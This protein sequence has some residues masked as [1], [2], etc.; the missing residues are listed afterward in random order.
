MKFVA[1]NG[2]NRRPPYEVI[3]RLL[4][5]PYGGAAAVQ[6]SITSANLWRGF[7]LTSIQLGTVNRNADFGPEH[8]LYDISK[9]KDGA[10]KRSFTP[11]D[12]SAASQAT[13][14]TA[15]AT[16]VTANT[17]IT[18]TAAE[19]IEEFP[20]TAILCFDNRRK[21]ICLKIKK[22]GRTTTV[23]MHLRTIENIYWSNSTTILPNPSSPTSTKGKNGGK[24]AEGRGSTASN[25]NPLAFRKRDAAPAMIPPLIEGLND[26]DDE[27][28]NNNGNKTE[29]DLPAPSG[30]DADIDDDDDESFV[31]E[32]DVLIRL[33]QPFVLEELDP[34]RNCGGLTRLVELQSKPH[35]TPYCFT[36]VWISGPNLLEPLKAMAKLY[37][38]PVPW[39]Q[40]IHRSSARRYRQAALEDVE[41]RL[42]EMPIPLAFQYQVGELGPYSF[43]MVVV[44]KYG[45]LTL[46]NI[47]PFHVT[48][49][50]CIGC[51]FRYLV[52]YL[53]LNSLTTKSLSHHSFLFLLPAP[54]HLLFRIALLPHL[55]HRNCFQIA[56]STQKSFC[57]R[58]I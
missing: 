51:A 14:S 9:A 25:I 22:K 45:G 33:S 32:H 28:N 26:D 44:G 6:Q 27:D 3:A 7:P 13:A 16:A 4:A 30:T 8:T 46:N 12:L 42:M 47:S 24:N 57:K 40:H 58:L 21:G 37:N 56:Y 36:D 52:T 31:P 18:T 2:R 35:I 19:T 55:H 1:A 11:P 29:D 49:L 53:G 38:T 20:H 39:E 23:R 43:V 34:G 17:S 50:L 15:T 10:T 54:Q 5:Q 41:D 48:P